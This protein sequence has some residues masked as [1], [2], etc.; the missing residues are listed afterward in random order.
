[1]FLLR[2]VVCLKGSVTPISEQEL[3][4][5]TNNISDIRRSNVVFAVTVPPKLGRLV[6]R[7]PDNSTRNIST[8]TQS[9]VGGSIHNGHLSL[10]TE[11]PPL[12][13]SCHS[14]VN[15]GVILYHQNQPKS[16]GWSASD[17]FSFTVSSPPAFLHPHTFTILI[18]YQARKR[19]QN[20]HSTSLMN[21]AG[22]SQN[23]SASPADI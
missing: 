16:V 15:H 6:Q 8:F 22:T 23:H 2:V 9:M 19:H 13:S 1:M 12:I 17:S 21:N 10:C 4:V 11:A 18:S 7:L 5:V 14:Q 20:P 3:Q